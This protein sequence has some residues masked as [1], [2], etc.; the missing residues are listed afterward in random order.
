MFPGVHTFQK[1]SSSNNNPFLFSLI[2]S[3]KIKPFQ[4][5]KK[6]KGKMGE[7]K[8]TLPNDCQIENQAIINH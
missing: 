4:N 7:L 1:V 3:R 8:R 6:K 2:L 5:E